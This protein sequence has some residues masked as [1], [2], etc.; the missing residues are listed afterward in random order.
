M[1][2]ESKSKKNVNNA[3]ISVP[4]G[5]QGIEKLQ[6]SHKG[7]NCSITNSLSEGYFIILISFS[8][9]EMYVIRG[10]DDSRVNMHGAIVLIPF[11]L[12]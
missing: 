5:K 6:N 7:L 3:D 9:R 12:L 10:K 4:T 11:N 1:I 8:S 2:R